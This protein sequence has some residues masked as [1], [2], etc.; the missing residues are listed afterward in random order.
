MNVTTD[1]RER[2]RCRILASVIQVLV[3]YIN[4]QNRNSNL[5]ANI[6]DCLSG[7][8]LSG[9]ECN[10]DARFLLCLFPPKSFEIKERERKRENYLITT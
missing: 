6:L 4:R 2:D 7:V 8:F 10:L 1:D 9:N 3:R 5:M